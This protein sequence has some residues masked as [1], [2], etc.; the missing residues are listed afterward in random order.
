MA[1]GNLSPRQKMI[2]MMYL[3]LTA[4]LALN[5]SK[6]ILDA[7]T[8]LD[9]DLVTTVKTVENK[10]QTIYGQFDKAMAENA[11]KTKPWRDKA[12]SIK[13]DADNLVA[14]IEGLKTE[15]IE[16]S[17]GRNEDDNK[18][19]GL[20][21][22]EKAANFLLNAPEVGGGG[23]ALEL[24]K[25]I[26]SFRENSK[27]LVTDNTFL[28]ESL[29]KV[30]N[31]SKTKVGKDG[32]E[33][34]WEKA[35]FEHYPLAAILPFLTGMQA[36]VRNAE[37]DIITH[38][39]RNIDASDLKFTGVTAV[40]MPRSTYIKQ[41]DEYYAEVFLAAYDDTKNPTIKINGQELSAENIV[42]GKGIVRFPGNTVGE[43][44]W[45]GEIIIQQ[46]GEDKP[47]PISG[48]YNVSPP[49]VVISPTAMNVLYRGVDNPLE[50]GVPGADPSK[51]DVRGP[52]LTKKSGG[53][54]IADITK[55]QGT[56]AKYEVFVK[57]DEGNTKKVGEKEFRVKGLPAAEGRIYNRPGG[58]FSS[59]AVKNATIQA[60]FVDFVF[61]LQVQVV[62]FE[63]VIPG[64]PPQKVNGDK[65]D[66]GTKTKIESLKP[67]SS[68][69][70][71]NI[72]AKGPKNFP[73]NN[74]SAISIDIN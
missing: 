41:G 59:N 68:I 45:E 23:K 18:I 25:K 42:A 39:Q 13:G 74:V 46:G 55:I 24:K 53:E 5:I 6:D 47:Y 49:S 4:L 62:S 11:T 30:F 28:T 3:V 16:I 31:T 67:G 57:D 10:I 65:F 66:S 21:N 2:N 56:S 50:V 17:G 12:Y 38:L 35:T 63:V 58:M 37:A 1:G 20:D 61:D 60:T 36:N 54:Y 8:K 48:L 29:N 27:Q 22:V 26:E 73:V 69:T 15:L 51:V 32:I 43:K 64:F 52:G 34:E 14:Y 44:K 7:L 71:R 9:D 19:K 70:V 72:K 40:V 33:T